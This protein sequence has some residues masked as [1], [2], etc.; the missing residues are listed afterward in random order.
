VEFTRYIW[1][2]YAA[3]DCGRAAIAKPADAYAASGDGEA[4]ELLRFRF[5]LCRDGPDGDPIPIEN[6]F[7]EADIRD[8]LRTCL[9]GR[10]VN[11]AET[12]E[13]LFNRVAGQLLAR[14]F[15]GGWRDELSLP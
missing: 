9:S 13:L 15:P 10:I 1:E 6:E 8:D 7:V 3:S 11:D 12:A 4:D 14:D 5:P 2:L